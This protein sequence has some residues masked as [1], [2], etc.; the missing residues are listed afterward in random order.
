MLDDSELNRVQ[1]VGKAAVVY[2]R[3]A[4]ELLLFLYRWKWG[5]DL[6][7]TCRAYCWSRMPDASLYGGGFSYAVGLTDGRHRG[8]GIVLQRPRPL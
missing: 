1:I 4:Y 7:G 2:I 6:I 3:H 5:N 8:R